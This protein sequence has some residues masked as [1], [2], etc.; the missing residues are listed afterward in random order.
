MVGM[1]EAEL[2]QHVNC[3]MTYCEHDKSFKGPNLKA[4]GQWF[5]DTTEVC[6]HLEAVGEEVGEVL[7]AARE[8]LTLS[9]RL[10]LLSEG[11]ATRLTAS[12]ERV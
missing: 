7:Q 8:N 3:E 11:R 9:L 10:N 4:A 1:N 6:R 5:L 12:H 2:N